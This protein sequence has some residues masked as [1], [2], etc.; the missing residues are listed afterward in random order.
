MVGARSRCVWGAFTRRGFA[1]FTLGDGLLH[2]D[3]PRMIQIQ[4]G[5][6]LRHPLCIGQAGVAV[7]G[8]ESGD[9]AGSADRIPDSFR[10]EVGGAR[11]TFPVAEIDTDGHALVAR[12]FDGLHLPEAY[13]DGESDIEIHPC[14][15]ST[16]ALVC[17]LSEHILYHLLQL[18][19]AISYIFHLL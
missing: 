1:L 5:L 2:A 3:V 13:A 11:R 7:F 4:I 17:G 15:G 6:R 12:M 8:G 19:L 16:G 10:F 18:R 14:L 9:V